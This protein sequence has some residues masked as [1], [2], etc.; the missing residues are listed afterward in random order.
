[1]GLG[2]DHRRLEGKPSRRVSEPVHLAERVGAGVEVGVERRALFRGQGGEHLFL[3]GVDVRA[4]GVGCAAAR[5]VVRGAAGQGRARY[6]VGDF[7]CTPSDTAD[8][9]TF[10]DCAGKGNTRIT[11]RY[12]AS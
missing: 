10:Y 6:E 3:K 2:A 8:G 9:D 1:M 12:G 5:D 11:F 4:T 7:V